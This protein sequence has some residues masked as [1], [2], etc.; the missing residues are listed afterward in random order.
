MFSG[1]KTKRFGIR[2][3]DFIH[4][5]KNCSAVIPWYLINP[6]AAN[7]AAPNTHIQLTVSI[8]TWGRSKKYKP[9]ATPQ[10]TSEKKN[11]LI[12]SLLS[13]KFNYFTCLPRREHINLQFVCF[14]VRFLEFLYVTIYSKLL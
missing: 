1:R 8:L 12:C 5:H 3:S 11:C 9:T 4:A 10:A 7:G 6:N 2:I 14:F 13:N